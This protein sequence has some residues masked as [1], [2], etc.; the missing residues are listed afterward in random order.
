ME[1]EGRV[2]T[3]Q[4]VSE[5]M[6]QQTQVATVIAYWKRWIERWPTIADLAKADVEVGDYRGLL[7]LICDRR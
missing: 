7:K 5:V 2:L 1:E 6:L 4:L 3:I